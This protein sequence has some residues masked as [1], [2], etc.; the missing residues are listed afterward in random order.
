MVSS[1]LSVAELEQLLED[2]PETVLVHVELED[3]FAAAHLPESKHCPVFAMSFADD[4][5]ELAPDRQRPIVFYGTTDDSH[6]PAFAAEKAERLGY[7]K[8][9]IFSGGVEAWKAAGHSVEGQSA[10]SSGTAAA[11]FSGRL[12]LDLERSEV[13]W[14]GRNIAS[15]HRGTV[16]L[17]RGWVSLREGRLVAGEIVLDM[18]ALTCSDITDPKMNAVLLKHLRDHDFFDTEVY[19]R[20]R[21]TLTEVGFDATVRPGRR[22]TAE[23]PN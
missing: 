12:P 4:L 17:S 13:E 1:F 16:G 22:I 3:A 18:N 6:A 10:G 23:P 2:V 7:R 21:V 8:V 14:T 15:L 11:A 20:A 5:Q 19:P 9:S